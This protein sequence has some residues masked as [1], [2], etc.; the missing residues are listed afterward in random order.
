[1]KAL[2]KELKYIHVFEDS[3]ALKVNSKI[4]HV[5]AEAK[6][7]AGEHLLN[8]TSGLVLLFRPATDI[9]NQIATF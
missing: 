8:I 1:M 9:R 7:E 4:K 2:Q 3:D 6:K 5:K